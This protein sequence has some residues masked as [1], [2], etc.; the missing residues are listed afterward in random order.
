MIARRRRLR[1][2][3]GVCTPE[4]CLAENRADVQNDGREQASLLFRVSSFTRKTS[5]RS[6][7]K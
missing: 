7:T 1:Y 4:K 3:I 5:N 6:R 2:G